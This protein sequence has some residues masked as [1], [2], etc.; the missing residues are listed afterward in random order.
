MINIIL[1]L[2]FFTWA[3]I[4]SGRLLSVG[5]LIIFLTLAM[6]EIKNK[7]IMIYTALSKQTNKIF[8]INQY[9]DT[10]NWTSSDSEAR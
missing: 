3:L 2:S 10:F 4:R 1:F 5:R 8:E 6:K 7:E 9:L